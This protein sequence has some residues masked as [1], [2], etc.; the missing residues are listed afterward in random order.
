MKCEGYRQKVY[1]EPV[2]R[3]CQILDLKDDDSLIEMYKQVHSREEAWPEIRHGIRQV[4]IL[5]ME[6]YLSGNHAIMIVD[7][8][9]NFDWGEAMSRLAGLPRQAEWEAFVARFQQC[10]SGSS[11]AEKWKMMERFFYLYDE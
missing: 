3:Y 9:V 11:S 7:T 10:E 4:G 8:P 6:L 1:S 2:K 5:E